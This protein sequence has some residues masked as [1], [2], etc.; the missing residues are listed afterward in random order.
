ML[1]SKD[2][3]ISFTQIET[4]IPR[5]VEGKQ[6]YYHLCMLILPKSTTSRNNK[7]WNTSPDT[8]AN[9][10]KLGFIQGC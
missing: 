1:I 3:Y 5:Y 9:Q 7:T 10:M 8:K 4:N 6:K 2:A